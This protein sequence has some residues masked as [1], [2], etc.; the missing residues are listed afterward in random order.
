MKGTVLICLKE[1]VIQMAGEA[2]WRE[3]LQAAHVDPFRIFLATEDVDEQE[4]ADILA[5]VCT[6]CNVT[7][8]QAGDAFGD[9]WVNTYSRRTYKAFY[10]KHTNARDFLADLNEMHHKLTKLIPNARPPAF[11]MTWLTS[12]TLLMTYQ[13]TRGLIDVAVGMTRAV[14]RH[15]G[16]PLAVR[17]LSSTQ[18]EVTF[19]DAREA[20]LRS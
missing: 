1:V 12:R 2:V 5:N 6:L 10:A 11:R 15:Y 16:T 18:F 9:Y 7:L 3:A 4:T 14:G 20:A 17:K 8:A 13:S 19:T